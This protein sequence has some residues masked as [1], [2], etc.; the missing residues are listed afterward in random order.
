MVVDNR[1]SGDL[2]TASSSGLNRFVITQNGNVGI[3]LTQPHAPLQF[4]AVTASRKIVLYENQNDDHQYYGFGVNANVLR[5]QVD[6]PVSSHIFYAGTSSTTSNELLRI[7]GNGK[8]GIGSTGPAA[9]V[10]ISDTRSAVTANSD[11]LA[12]F[13]Q[14]TVFF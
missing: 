10:Q 3:G 1:G 8:V 14:N 5:Y 4:A 12:L 6:L 2:F 9:H 7:Q 11:N 13:L